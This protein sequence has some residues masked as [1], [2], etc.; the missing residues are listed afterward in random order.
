[1]AWDESGGKLCGSVAS[2]IASPPCE[3][4]AADGRGCLPYFMLNREP[5]LIGMF[6]DTARVIE[7]CAVDCG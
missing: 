1:M 6:G 7:A 3:S 2:A 5:A 4:S